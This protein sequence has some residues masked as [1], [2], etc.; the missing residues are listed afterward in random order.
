MKRTLRLYDPTLFWL[1]MIATILGM[2]FVFDAGY[3]RSIDSG[4]SVMPREFVMQA[5]LFPIA[6]VASFLCAGTRP[7]KW[8]KIAKTCWWISFASLLFVFFPVIGVAMNGAHRWIKFGPIVIQPAEFVKATCVLYLASVL[9][10]RKPWPDKIKFR[11]NVEW[12]DRVMVPKIVRAMPAIVAF[13]AVGLIE[14]EPD[15][16]TGAIVAFTAF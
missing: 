2:L 8:K 6:L 11:N 16:G 9:A 5:V 13:L 15:M 7:D 4:H 1:A 3:A 14:K 12:A 10:D